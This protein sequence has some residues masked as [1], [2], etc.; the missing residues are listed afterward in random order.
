MTE[1]LK[2]ERFDCFRFPETKGITGSNL[3]AEYWRIIGSP[4]YNAI[5]NPAYAVSAI[6]ICET[7]RPAAELY[8]ERDLGTGPTPRI[9]EQK[10]FVGALDLIAV[11]QLLFKDSESYRMP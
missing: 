5:R 2:I 10:P 9:A 11:D 4:L 3:I 1:S 8:I 7:F 6:F